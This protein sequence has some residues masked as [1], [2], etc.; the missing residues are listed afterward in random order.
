MLTGTKYHSVYSIFVY[1]Q[2]SGGCSHTNALG[3]GIDDLYGVLHGERTLE[4]LEPPHEPSEILSLQELHHEDLVRVVK[5]VQFGQE[6]VR[7]VSQNGRPQ[8]Q[9]GH[10]L[11]RDLL[12]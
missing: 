3:G 11:I 9:D 6:L 7:L 1:A 2:K 10:L 4:D 5:V 12:K 8:L